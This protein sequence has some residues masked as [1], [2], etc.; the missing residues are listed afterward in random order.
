LCTRE[1]W[2]FACSNGGE[3]L[4]PYGPFYRET[5]CN[6]ENGAGLDPVGSH[7]GCEGGLAGL[8]DMSGNVE[9][10]IDDCTGGGNEICRA[11][12][13]R[14]GADPEDLTCTRV[15]ADRR[16]DSEAYRGFRC[17]L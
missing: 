11:I 5:A 17:C 3:R 4:Y 15:N 1:E 2:T 16:D 6:G 14:V 13:G 7:L 10:W 8:F 9:E 12:G